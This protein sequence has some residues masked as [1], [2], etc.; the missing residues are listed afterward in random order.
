MSEEPPVNLRLLIDEAAA[1]TY[2]PRARK[3][4][5]WWHEWTMWETEKGQRYQ[6]RHCVGCG[7]AVRNVLAKECVHIWRTI[8]KARIM[9]K[10]NDLPI[11]RNYYQQCDE[12][13]D[14]RKKQLQ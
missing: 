4:W 1:Q 3:C 14:C 13:G 10:G 6:T 11:G 8:E 5:P 12:C 9:E 7:L 2:N